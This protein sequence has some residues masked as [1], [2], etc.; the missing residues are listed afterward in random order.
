MV[1]AVLGQSCEL[2]VCAVGRGLWPELGCRPFSQIAL[3][4][5]VVSR[6]RCPR[7]APVLV[8]P[9]EQWLWVVVASGWLVVVVESCQFC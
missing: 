1:S 7:F 3:P 5:V 8:E 2:P 9:A 4:V 6:A